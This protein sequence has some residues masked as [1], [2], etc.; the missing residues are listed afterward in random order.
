MKKTLILSA[1][2]A[3]VLLAT[4]CASNADRR[5]EQY[6]EAGQ[7][8]DYNLAV[9][10]SEE[11]RIR[12]E[13]EARAAAQAKL[14]AKAAAA[15][16]KADRARAQANAKA[17]AAKKARQQKLDAYAERER[18]LKLRLK[19]LEVQAR[20]AEVGNIVATEKA[21]TETARD[22]VQLELEQLRAQVKALE[23]QK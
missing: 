3:A 7:Q 17:A 15:R 18:E 6:A 9:I 4:G 23:A 13:E 12:A 1:C 20:E 5:M 11:S 19:E 22:K 10:Q 14:D 8:M 2:V 21:R 16:Q